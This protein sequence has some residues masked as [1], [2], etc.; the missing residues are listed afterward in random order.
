[1]SSFGQKVFVTIS[2]EGGREMLDASG[3]RIDF[4]IRELEGFS[5][6]TVT[7]WN[8]AEETI[9]LLSDGERYVNIKT[10]LHD[11]AILTIAEKLYVSNVLDEKNVPDT[12]T[13]L[14]CYS[15]IKKDSLTAQM[16]I[17]VQAPS[18]ANMVRDAAQGAG[19][20][21][22]VRYKFF[23]LG[24]E[25][26][27]PPRPT[28][29]LQGSFQQIMREL[30]KEY[31]FNTYTNATEMILVYKPDLG[32]V[33]LTDMSTTPAVTLDT[34]NMRA[35]PKLGPAQMQV[36][37]NLDPAM[38]PG[39]LLDISKLLTAGITAPENAK[40]YAKDFLKKSVAG[41][42][43]YICLSVQHKASTHGDAWHTLITA[44]A[45]TRGK[46]MPVTNW[47]R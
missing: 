16:D 15:L 18:L 40:L 22:K 17:T 36:T 23:P 44:V 35:N 46:Q 42:N 29:E 13:T 19:F 33:G 32:Q 21:G 45:P 8:L 9:G 27:M 31:N 47:F 37:S 11:G 30:G 5:R 12:I 14:F 34:A 25:T 41:Y 1:M 26:Y 43:N 20:T 4:D 24:Y 38:I 7:L 28:A 10:Q 39:T 3:L 2:D 6:G